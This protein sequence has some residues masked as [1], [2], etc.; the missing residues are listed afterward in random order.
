M[1]IGGDGLAVMPPPRPRDACLFR[2]IAEPVS[3]TA[4]G[5]SVDAFRRL[6]HAE[7][8]SRVA[9]AYRRKRYGRIVSGFCSY[10]SRPHELP[11]IRKAYQVRY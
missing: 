2:R 9:H 10:R 8:S 1:L 4:M 6:Y 5:R 3:A 7:L 11:A